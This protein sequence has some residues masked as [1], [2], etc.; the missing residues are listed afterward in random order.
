ML[1]PLLRFAKQSGG[2]RQKKSRLLQRDFFVMS[3]LLRF[4]DAF[5]GM[6]RRNNR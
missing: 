4:N 6:L 1:S 5:G 2:E 3:I